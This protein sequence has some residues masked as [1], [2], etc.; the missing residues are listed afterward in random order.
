MAKETQRQSKAGV[1]V[2]FVRREE[3]PLLPPPPS[4]VG[5]I[6]WLYKN[7]FASMSDFGSIGATFR[8]LL[9]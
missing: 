7:I 4:Q 9:M 3:A 6:G 5:L 8:S 1:P 2:A